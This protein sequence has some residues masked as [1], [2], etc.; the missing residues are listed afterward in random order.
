M[1]GCLIPFPF[2]TIFRLISSDK[3]T[4][5]KSRFGEY[6]GG[7]EAGISS[8]MKRVPKWLQKQID[9]LNRTG[10]LDAVRDRYFLVKGRHFLY[11]LIPGGHGNAD[12]SVYRKPRRR[13]SRR[14]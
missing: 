2:G 8:D 9:H 11:Y 14:K 7:W 4:R 10:K 1:S 12:L 6:I 5:R 3:L 13:T